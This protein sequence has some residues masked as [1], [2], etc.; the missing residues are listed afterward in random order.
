MSRIYINFRVMKLVCICIGLIV[1]LGVRIV[2][3]LMTAALIAI[4]AGTSRNISRS[5]TQYAIL[6]TLCGLISC[7]AG[8]VISHGYPVP[9]GSAIIL[10][11]AAL[12]VLSL[13]ARHV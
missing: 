3:G 11:S 5:V 10:S 12:F 6:S 7:M 8:V 9:V 2:G 1:G 4:P 13:A